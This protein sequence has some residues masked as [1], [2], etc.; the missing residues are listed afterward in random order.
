MHTLRQAIPQQVIIQCSK[1]LET[2][3][4]YIHSYVK[5]TKQSSFTYKHIMRYSQSSKDGTEWLTPYSDGSNVT[6]IC[7]IWQSHHDVFISEPSTL[8]GPTVLT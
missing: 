8:K 7:S 3:L 2:P 1:Y 4:E 6:G 5:F